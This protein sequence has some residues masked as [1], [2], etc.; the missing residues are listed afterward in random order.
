MGLGNFSLKSYNTFGIDAYADNFIEITTEDQ[1]IEYLKTNKDFFVLGGGSNIVLTQNI[2]K[3]VLYINNKG[4]SVIEEDDIS[5]LI[6]V[7][8]GEVWNDLVMW[9]V[10]KNYGGIENLSLIPG[11]V[12]ASPIQNI[13]A[14]GVEVKDTI[15]RVEAVNI[16]TGC[17]EIF[18]NKQCE[19][20]YRTSVF[21]TK[22]KN[23]YIITNVFF[24]LKKES[25][26]LSTSYGDIEKELNYNN[27]INPTVKNIS[28]A[29]VKIRKSKLPDPEVLGNSGSFFKNPIVSKGISLQK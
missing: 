12:G 22:Y 8:A 28:D 27:I 19:F 26:K 1:L 15:D 18:T 6:K 5:L 10:D 23:K 29:I 17:I 21:K 13:G 14:Y 11:K 9:V 25:Y 2:E 20:E 3:D 16:T 4:V 7:S 24:R